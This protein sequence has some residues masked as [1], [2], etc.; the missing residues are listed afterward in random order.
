MTYADL[1]EKLKPLGLAEV[2]GMVVDGY[3]TVWIGRPKDA[4]V[5]YNM[6]IH[7]LVLDNGAATEIDDEV[8]DAIVRRFKN[9]VPSPKLEIL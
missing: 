2:G 4:I 5:P 8:Y 9:S 3:N 7:P 1:L 6:I